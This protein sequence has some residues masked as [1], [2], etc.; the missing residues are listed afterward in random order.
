MQTMRIHSRWLV[1][2]SLIALVGVATG[3]AHTPA[4]PVAKDEKPKVERIVVTGSHIP[5][6]VEMRSGLANTISPVRIYTRDQLTDTGRA[7]DAGAALR[8]L[9]PSLT[10]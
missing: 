10:Y 8:A 1:G 5:R 2:A 6:T 7:N 9:D 4:S 3:C